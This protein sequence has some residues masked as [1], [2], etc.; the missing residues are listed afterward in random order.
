LLRPFAAGRARRAVGVTV[1]LVLWGLITHGTFA[2]TGDEPHYMMIARSLVVGGDLDLADDYAD[3]G[4]PIHLGTL[5]V[6]SHARPG[7]NGA[8][9]PVHDVGMPILAAPWFAVAHATAVRLT[10]ALPE[11]FLRRA[12]LNRWLVLRHLLSFGMMA[13]AAALA[14]R[15]FDVFATMTADARAAAAGAALAVLSPPLLTHAYLFFTEIP[16]AALALVA[17][18]M[19]SGE[20]HDR[21]WLVCAGFLAGLLVLVHVRNVGLAFGL[22]VVAWRTPANRSPWLVAGAAV[23]L[24]V[25]TLV[26]A[27]FWGSLVTGPHARADAAMGVFGAARESAVRLLGLLLDQEHGLLPY[28]PIYLLAPLGWFFLRRDDRR[29][30]SDVALIVLAYLLPVLCPW[31]NVHGWRGGWSPAA[32]ML[33]P[34]VPFLAIAAFAGAVR[35]KR[36]ALVLAL[37]QIGILQLL[38]RDPKLA[39]NDGDGY[40]EYGDAL[41]PGGAAWLPSIGE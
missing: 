30:A 32:R 22:L 36:L 17:W 24:A 7:R 8:L 4:N 37:L 39:W 25:R 2:G 29:A 13:V 28:A 5:A 9:R 11:A 27:V 20:R 18:R 12:R 15:L 35:R 21:A 40:A 26:N 23:P 1:F 31:T 33:V 34:V 10:P 38:W 3:A 16:S 41:F 19:L 14:M 6:E